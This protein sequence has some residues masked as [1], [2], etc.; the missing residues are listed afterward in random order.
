MTSPDRDIADFA[1]NYFTFDSP[2]PEG[3]PGPSFFTAFLHACA[4]ATEPELEHLSDAYPDYVA[5]YRLGQTPDG[6][7]ILRSLAHPARV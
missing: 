2:N 3:V 1:L 6:L 4:L 5:A 7:D